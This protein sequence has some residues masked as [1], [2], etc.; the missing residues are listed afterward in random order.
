MGWLGTLGKGLG[1]AGAIV[2]APFTGGA[3]L[4]ALGPILSAG[5][6][7]LQGI[8]GVAGGAAKGAQQGR[9]QD[10]QTALL[11]QQLRQQ[12]ANSANQNAMS[13]ANFAVG[14]RDAATK[15]SVMSGLL[16]GVQ[17][18]NIGRPEGSTIPTF[19]ISGGMRPS[20]LS[21]E[22]RAA[23]MQQLSAGPMAAPEFRDVPDMELPEAGMGE[24]LLGGVGLAGGLLGA[25]GA[26]LPTP[27]AY[28]G[29]F[30]R[31]ATSAPVTN[32]AY[33]GTV[34][35]QSPQLQQPL[36]TM[37]APNVLTMAPHVSQKRPVRT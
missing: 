22:A 24:K 1:V 20:A 32:S 18:V 17:D 31:P 30:N 13:R 36:A 8:G 5:S 6:G 37:N 27:P 26:N 29:T 15:R 25:I 7:I 3:S 12:N 11:Q 34:L 14:E 2:G 19:N 10:T 16:G 35:P 9:Q 4:A 33:G 21:P 28:G 23:I